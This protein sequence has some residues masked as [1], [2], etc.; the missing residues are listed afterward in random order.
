[1][2]G[3]V[4]GQCG[5]D[6]VAATLPTLAT[7]YSPDLVIVNGENVTNGRGL[8]PQHAHQLFNAGTDVITLGNHAWD[9][10]ELA[11]HLHN[12]PRI[13]RPGNYPEGS[14]GKGCGIFIADNGVRVG[15]ANIMGRVHMEPLDD[16]FRHADR[17]VDYFNTEGIKVTFIDFHAEATSEKQAFAYFVDG[18]VSTVVGTHTHVQTA[19]EQILPGGTAYITDVGMTGPQHSIIGMGLEPVLKKFTT[20]RPVRLDVASGTAI[21]NGV[22][23]EVDPQTGKAQHIKRISM[24]NIVEKEH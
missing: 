11:A 12:E 2:L 24:R 8:T 21:L 22:V 13:L 1:M 16:P 15:V 3:D 19:D 4:V 20:Q 14:P 23:V 6:A 10:K 5:L 9:Q 7:L 17:I 18:R